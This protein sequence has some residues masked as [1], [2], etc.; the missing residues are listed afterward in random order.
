MKRIFLFVA[1]IA[2]AALPVSAQDKE[3]DRIRNSGEVM[4]EILNI[5]DDIPADV[6]NGIR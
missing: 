4:V 1:A 3:N 5:P 6:L 2:M